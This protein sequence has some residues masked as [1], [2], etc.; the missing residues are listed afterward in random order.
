LFC[1][2]AEI[3]ID[4]DSYQ[5]EDLPFEECY[6]EGEQIMLE[7]VPGP[8][9][10]F[11]GW[12]NDDGPLDSSNSTTIVY[13]VGNTAD[14]ISAFFNT[15][16][17]DLT[18]NVE[19]PDAGTYTINGTEINT[20]TFTDEF[21]G[22]TNINL[23]AIASEHYKFDG[24]YFNSNPSINS[25]NATFDFVVTQDETITVVFTPVEYSIEIILDDSITDGGSI[26]VDGQVFA[27]GDAIIFVLPYGEQIDIQAYAEFGFVFDY[28][29]S[30]DFTI[31]E[32]NN[33]GNANF[34]V[35]GP[36]VISVF[37]AEKPPECINVNA[38]AFSPNSDGNNETFA[39]FFFECD[40]VDYRLEIFDRWGTEVFSTQDT[41]AI[42]NG[43]NSDMGVY[44]FQIQ[45]SYNS[46]EGEFIEKSIVGNL[47]LIR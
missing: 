47:T 40:I 2:V 34:I 30:T 31:N 37:F 10:F 43:N 21:A 27:S 36:G 45:Y 29:E 6:K 9:T 15:E 38:T 39:P 4:G 24:W 28:W 17:F 1:T 33:I 22:G 35:T 18:F 25:S 5:P 13:T 46:F 12:Q 44:V 8:G 19:P 20:E 41:N 23:E 32:V 7:V 14:N 26:L 42:W 3:I 16:T 11:G